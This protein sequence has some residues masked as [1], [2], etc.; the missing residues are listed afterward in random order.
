MTDRGPEV[1]DRASDAGTNDIRDSEPNAQE[2]GN[3]HADFGP[4]QFDLE[5]AA[6]RPSN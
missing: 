2:T 5:T 6:A 3:A 4:T 1:E